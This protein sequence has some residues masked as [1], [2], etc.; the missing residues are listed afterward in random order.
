MSRTVIGLVGGIASGKSMVASLFAEER[1]AVHLDADGV[2][3][4]VL[5]RPA[6]V[7]AVARRIPGA[8]GRDGKMDR[9]KLA[10]KVFSDPQAL[11]ALEEIT[12][13]PIRRA[14]ERALRR[15]RAPYVLLDAALLQE[16]GA[17]ELCDVVVYVACPARTRRA[18][19]RSHRG[20]SGAEHRA[21]E[22]RQWSL[23]RK[24]AGADL[25]VDN[26]GDEA[27]TRRD[28]RR[29]LRTLERRS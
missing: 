10:R 11:A 27:R 22:A 7:K 19:A 25:V 23:R 8:L 15:A 1:S 2:A 20:W 29:V 12:H 9:Q 13:P 5:A 14:L 6:V 16:T 3:R 24:R 17:D 26:A 21:R 28:V 18:R 4:R